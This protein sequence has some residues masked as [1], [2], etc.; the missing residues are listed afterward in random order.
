[1]MHEVAVINVEDG[2][3]IQTLTGQVRGGISAAKAINYLPDPRGAV[4]S[5]YDGVI[6]VWRLP[7]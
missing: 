2:E 6:R 3:V 4:S 1:M 7:D 5:G